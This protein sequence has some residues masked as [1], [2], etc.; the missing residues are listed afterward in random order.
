MGPLLKK[1]NIWKTELFSLEEMLDGDGNMTYY[2]DNV[3]II[4]S[5]LSTRRENIQELKDHL[6]KI[7]YKLD[8]V[9]E[10]EI[11]YNIDKNVIEHLQ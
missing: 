8:S 10:E 11:M 5:S 9:S 2:L 3:G 1:R 7:I 4:C 6:K